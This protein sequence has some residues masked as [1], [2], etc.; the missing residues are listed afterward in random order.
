MYHRQLTGAISLV[1]LLGAACGGSAPAIPTATT[2]TAPTAGPTTAAVAT[3]TAL[4]TATRPAGQMAHA[5][6]THTAT[7]LADGRVLVAGGWDGLGAAAWADL[8][9]PATGTFAATGPMASARGFF[10]ATRLSDGRVLLAGGT[11]STWD[12]AGPMLVSTELFDP[13][14]DTLQLSRIDDVATL[15]AHRDAAA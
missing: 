11:P 14:T 1:A 5:H 9:D 2:T 7:A 13:R 3:P 12:F 6:S 10:T 15:R 8:Y 4:P